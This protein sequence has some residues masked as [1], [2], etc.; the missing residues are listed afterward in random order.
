M[1]LERERERERDANKQSPKWRE[2]KTEKSWNP[3]QRFLSMTH[4]A[5]SDK[6]RFSSGQLG[7]SVLNDVTN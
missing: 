4:A 2:G 6:T 1:S 5:T 3:F 7:R